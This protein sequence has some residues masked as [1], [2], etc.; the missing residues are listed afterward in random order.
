VWHGVPLVIALRR[1]ALLLNYRCE[2]IQNHRVNGSFD[3]DTR[4]A[5][6]RAVDLL[7]RRV[8]DL[9]EQ[10]DISVASLGRR[11]GYSRGGLRSALASPDGP[12]LSVLLGLAAHLDLRSIEELFGEFGT[13]SAI[14]SI[15]SSISEPEETDRD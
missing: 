11:L 6:E 15:R 9:A 7:R 10:R 4:A 12:K 8:R 5:Q 14:E 1:C 13:T 3:V 2:I